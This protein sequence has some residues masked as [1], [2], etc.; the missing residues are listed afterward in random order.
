MHGDGDAGDI[1]QP[2]RPH[3]NVEGAFGGCFDGGDIGHIFF[4]HARGLV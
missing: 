1:H 2:K 3:A 4:E